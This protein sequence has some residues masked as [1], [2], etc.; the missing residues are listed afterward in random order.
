MDVVYRG[1]CG[2]P[3]WSAV[4]RWRLRGAQGVCKSEMF[5]VTS[6]WR[7]RRST[8]CCRPSWAAVRCM[9]SALHAL[10]DAIASAP[11]LK[12]YP[13]FS[14][15]HRHFS[16][17]NGNLLA[18]DKQ[19]LRAPY[20]ILFL[21]LF[22]FI[23]TSF[24]VSAKFIVLLCREVLRT[25]EKVFSTGMDVIVWHSCFPAILHNK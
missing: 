8:R 19:P 18:R 3:L 23:S 22:N 13:P 14:L 20:L 12:P 1:I 5:F 9:T 7:Q 17:P 2:A 25:T 16:L 24:C 4:G 6:S 10:L 15:L 21:L 11:N